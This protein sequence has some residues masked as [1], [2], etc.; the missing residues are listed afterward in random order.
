[1]YPSDELALLRARKEIVLAR[2]TLLRAECSLAAAELARPIG[3]IE[4]AAGWVKR[5]S[6]FLALTSLFFG[7]RKKPD[8]RAGLFTTVLKYAPFVLR[9]FKT[10][11]SASQKSQAAPSQPES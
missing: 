6:P 2:S 11:R 10:F 8:K 7:A 9:L 3:L 4:T 5:L 1:M